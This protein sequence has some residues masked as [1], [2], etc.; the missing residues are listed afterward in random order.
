MK[1]KVLLIEPDYKNKYP[2]MGLMKLATYFRRCGD[3]VRFFKGDL[4]LF[5]AEL[6]CEEYFRKIGKPF[7]LASYYSDLADYIRSGKYLFL[8]NIPEF[9]G[10]ERENIIKEYR[11]RFVKKEIPQF[12]IV[13]VTTL[14]TFYWKKTVDTINEAKAFL[15]PK[16][17]RM[18]VGGIA[19]SI[20]PNEFYEATGIHPQEGLLDKPGVIDEGNYDIIDE[21]PLDYS[22]LEE[23]EYKYPASDAYF[24]YMTRGC[25]RNCPFCAVKTLEPKYKNY[26]SI[27]EQ[28]KT[29]DEKFGAKRDLLLMDNN[30]F[31]SSC[32]NQIIDEIIECGFA[33]GAKYKAPNEYDITYRNIIAK[34]NIRAYKKKMICL[35]DRITEKLP[36]KE[37]GEFY[38]QR[39]ELGL[40]YPQTAEINAIR[41]LDITARAYYNKYFKFGERERYIDFNQGLDARLATD[42]KMKKLS[43]I[44]IRPLRIA[45]DH[46]DQ[47]E[48]Y[49]N[50]IKMAAK[51]GIKHLSNYLLYNFED[52]PDE[53]YYRMRINVE[54]CEE[55]D[56][57]IY[58]F[59]M[60]YHPISDPDY[61]DNR[62]YI[63][64][65]WN[66]KFIRAI[67]A[68]L[69]STK[70][71]IGRGVSFFE[72]AFGTDIKEFEK[73]LWMPETF[74]IYRRVYDAELRQRLADR[75]PTIS[76]NDCNLANEWW[77]KFQ[78]LSPTK[79]EKVKKIIAE[80]KFDGAYNTA[81]KAVL[82]ILKY[83]EIKRP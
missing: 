10:T 64:K 22:I 27:K 39:E 8:D 83:Y 14:F 61:F 48:V 54:L 53:L 13:G 68:I 78:A 16:K 30:V 75:Y 67:Q 66:R 43:Q 71:K 12:D 79:S 5:A 7:E 3:D 46:Y 63:G 33:K 20:L 62:D 28:L 4:K 15:K 74:I 55:L 40:L 77:D 58:S 76:D 18:L 25:P 11:K 81:D 38:R 52:T 37:Q 26:I 9:R 72:E 47:E 60:K 2:P 35:Y 56:V 31:A 36:E 44:N 6:L 24:G 73:L 50:A 32:F 1:R 80:N 17:G 69:N 65:H 45:F 51:H 21:L 19:A 70:G 59:P 29:V 41:E 23:I 49:K 34:Y 82:D 42:E 57:T